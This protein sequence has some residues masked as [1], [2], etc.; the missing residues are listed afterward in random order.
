M[1]VFLKG[2]S[3]PKKEQQ[4]PQGGERGLA[5]GRNREDI[6]TFERIYSSKTN[7]FERMNC[8]YA[9]FD[10]FWVKINLA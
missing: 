6:S 10:W 9:G 8:I 2:N 3:E 7:Q 1:V 5:D 4:I